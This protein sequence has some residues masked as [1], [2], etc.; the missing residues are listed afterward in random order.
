MT[1]KDDETGNVV[2]I[3]SKPPVKPISADRIISTG[4]V[5]DKAYPIEPFDDAELRYIYDAPGLSVV[6]DAAEWLDLA[7]HEAAA[8]HGKHRT[9]R[10][11]RLLW[12]DAV[13]KAKAFL[14]AA[15]V[16]LED[17]HPTIL[18]TRQF[19][20]DASKA[21]A[22]LSMLDPY[23]TRKGFKRERPDAAANRSITV[24]LG[25][26]FWV[27]FNVQPSASPN[28]PFNRFVDAF[29]ECMSQNFPE[30][31]P[32]KLPASGTILKHLGKMSRHFQ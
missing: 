31:G 24:F 22:A 20:D 19:C 25:K 11:Q 15:L 26:A 13:I 6:G 16:V 18:A 12:E 5:R 32:I 10:E 21:I 7:A 17:D 3:Q 2:P 9:S 30:D 28:G 29:L 4:L 14:P 8:D 27:A 1:A 23:R